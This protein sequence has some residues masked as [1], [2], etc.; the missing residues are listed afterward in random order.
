MGSAPPLSLPLLCERLRE[1]FRML[2][3]LFFTSLSS[4]DDE[5]LLRL[6]D[7]LAVTTTVQGRGLQLYARFLEYSCWT[8]TRSSCSV[9]NIA[10]TMITNYV[11]LDPDHSRFLRGVGLCSF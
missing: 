4:S 5:L 8:Y 9:R 1:C 3:T 10:D 6:I 7:E 11:T 2:W